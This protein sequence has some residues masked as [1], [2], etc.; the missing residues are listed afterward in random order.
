[1]SVPFLSAVFPF[2]RVQTLSPITAR[3][4]FAEYEHDLL[5]LGIRATEGAKNLQ[6]RTSDLVAA[7]FRDSSG[8]GF[9]FRGYVHDIREWHRPLQGEDFV[10]HQILCVGPSY[11][12]KEPHSRTFQ[13]VQISD[14]AR[15]IARENYLNI[16]TVDPG[17][18]VPKIHQAGESDWAFLARLGR[19]YGFTLYCDGTTLHFHPRDFDLASAYN[20]A[21]VI[22]WVDGLGKDGQQAIDFR[23]LLGEINPQGDRARAQR[24]VRGVDPL[25]N[26][27]DLQTPPVP[28]I[29]ARSDA[30]QPAFDAYDT[31]LV[32][33]TQDWGLALAQGA[34]ESVRFTHSGRLLATGNPR[35]RA[36]SQVYLSNFHGEYDGYWY[37]REA[38]HDIVMHRGLYR[39]ECDLGA[40]SLG[41][42]TVPPPPARPAVYR[43]GMTPS[44]PQPTRTLLSSGAQ[45]LAPILLATKGGPPIGRW[46]SSQF[47]GDAAA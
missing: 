13:G 45:P 24:H 8:Q 23:P 39:M 38:V 46:R 28:P 44:L 14:V 7:T 2:N 21:Q 22:E 15:Q 17:F 10:V 29:T 31:D 16:V 43:P 33:P 25:G 20:K 19:K 9:T 37:V 18:T 40:D 12:L 3:M 47:T 34:A 42:T 11:P 6:L 5:T 41:P 27:F 26:T 36:G 30:P 1:M 32:A 4:R 35:T